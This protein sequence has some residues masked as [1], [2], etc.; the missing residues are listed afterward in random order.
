MVG[1]T[2]PRDVHGADGTLVL[3]DR[4]SQVLGEYRGATLSYGKGRVF[5][6]WDLVARPSG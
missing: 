3:L 1:C 5:M 2:L 4:G 6:V